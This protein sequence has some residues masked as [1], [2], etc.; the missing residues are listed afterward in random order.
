MFFNSAKI[1]KKAEPLNSSSS[2][3]PSPSMA[4]G[5]LGNRHRWTVIGCVSKEIARAMSKVLGCRYVSN[6]EPCTALKND[7]KH[8]QR[9]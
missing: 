4:V 6:A 5:Y 3:L 7:L 8:V 9:W 1:L 2:L